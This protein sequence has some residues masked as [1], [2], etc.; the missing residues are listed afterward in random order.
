M[1]KQKYK[2]TF[3]CS[4]CKSTFDKITTN[5]NLMSPRCPYCKEENEATKLHR[6]G[7]G[8]ISEETLIAQKAMKLY[9]ETPEFQQSLLSK[10]M[11][12]TPQSSQNTNKAI[13]VTAE[14]V[15]QDHKMGNITDKKQQPGETMAPRLDPVRQN[16]ADNMFGKKKSGLNTCL[17]MG[18]GRA[19]SMGDR[20]INM[21]ALARN[22]MAGAYRGGSI[23]PVA[24]VQNK[25]EPLKVQYVNK[26]N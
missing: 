3:K 23:D 15:M 17:D 22:A 1:T 21:G 4:D 2:M 7:D 25:R 10:M 5:Q 18:T 26:G 12:P 13:D 11:S 16:M 19:R 20:G 24:A 6:I 9:M 14:I 8:P